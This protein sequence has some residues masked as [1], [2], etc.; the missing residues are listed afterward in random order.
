MHQLTSNKNS[1]V[2]LEL[3][4]TVR[5]HVL[6]M[7]KHSNNNRYPPLTGNCEPT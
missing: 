5:K 1:A 7:T 3:F 2:P 6:S 4:E